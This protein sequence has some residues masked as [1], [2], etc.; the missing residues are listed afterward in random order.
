MLYAHFPHSFNPTIGDAGVE[1]SCTGGHIAWCHTIG[2]VLKGLCAS[3]FLAAKG[4]RLI[5]GY[6]WVNLSVLQNPLIPAK[7]NVSW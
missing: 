4:L 2:T 1:F 6:H 5:N 3:P 7:C